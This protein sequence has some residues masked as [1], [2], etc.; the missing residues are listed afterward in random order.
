MRRRLHSGMARGDPPDTAHMGAT[1]VAARGLAVFLVGG[2]L[3]RGRG[4][5]HD[6][7]RGQRL[8]VRRVAAA[9]AVARQRVR[10]AGRRGAAAGARWQ[11]AA[12][13]HGERARAQVREVARL[14]LH[15]GYVGG[16]GRRRQRHGAPARR[17]RGVPR[18]GVR[19][20]APV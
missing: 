4:P 11:V 5:V 13:V 20:C 6:R 18:P 16:F 10:A 7:V 3:E 2:G 14:P 17:G 9:A 1:V 19:V 12:H 15:G 8:P